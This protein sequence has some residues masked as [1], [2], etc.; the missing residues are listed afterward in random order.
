MIKL[1]PLKHQQLADRTQ[2]PKIR[3]SKKAKYLIHKGNIMINKLKS[4]ITEMLNI[5]KINQMIYASATVITEELGV[6]IKKKKEK[7]HKQPAWKERIS[8]D[9]E[10]L[11]KKLSILTEK[12]NGKT[13]SQRKE[14]SPEC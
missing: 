10:R 3:I 9:I 2:L 14:R 6:T 12:A 13:V 5:T 4:E 7:K 11:R 1:K 8:K